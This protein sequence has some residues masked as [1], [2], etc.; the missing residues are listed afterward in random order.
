M[1]HNT[2]CELNRNTTQTVLGFSRHVFLQLEKTKGSDG[3]RF[4]SCNAEGS[5]NKGGGQIGVA[6]KT[7]TTI[8]FD[9]SC[10]T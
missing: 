6:R 9:T 5:S 10:E 8:S 2:V 4:Q 7:T 3:E 1:E